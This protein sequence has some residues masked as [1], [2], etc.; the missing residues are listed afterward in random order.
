[1]SI[2]PEM[3]DAMVA[4][5][6]T[7]EQMATLMKAAIA[8]EE[9][10][11]VARRAKAAAK[12]RRQ[13]ATGKGN[14]S[15]DVPGTDGDMPGQKGTSGDG[16]GHGSPTP[17]D[18]PR[19][20]PTPHP[21][22]LKPPAHSGSD[23]DGSA[24]PSGA[25]GQAGGGE[26]GDGD[27]PAEAGA[28]DP[29]LDLFNRGKDTLQR[30]TGRPDPVVRALLGKWLRFCDD[31]ALTIVLAIDAAVQHKP[32]DAVSFIV[33]KL[34][35]DVAAWDTKLEKPPDRGS[36]DRPLNASSRRALLLRQ[37]K[38][39]H[40]APDDNPTPRYDDGS[41]VIDHEEDGRSDPDLLGGAGG[42]PRR[43][44]PNGHLRVA[45]SRHR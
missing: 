37:I 21:T 7:R 11:K 5:G 25:S 28:Y 39:D 40:D 1:M 44:P 20:S 34:R 2:T 42:D 17:L 14:M 38:R 24:P 12:K 9:A 15:P 43:V 29:R 31:D 19:P 23:P 8:Q 10:E 30:M 45:S 18:V 27:L 16:G 13:R 33:G 22:P 35:S 3:I 26:G 4:A 6:L 41:P 32:A 36:P